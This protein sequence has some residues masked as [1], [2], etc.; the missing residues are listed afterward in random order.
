[1][2]LGRYLAVAASVLAATMPVAAQTVPDAPVAPAPTPAPACSGCVAK[3]TIVEVIIDADLGSKLS[4]TGATFPLHLNKPIVI[5]GRDVV[6]AG[7]AGQGEVVHA[8][9]AG[10]S[11][12]AGEL[13]LAARFLTVGDRQLKLRSMRIALAGRDATGKVDAYNAAAAGAAVLTPLPLGLLGFAITGKNI[14]VPKG[15]LALAKTA[16]DFPVA[17]APA[18]APAPQVQAEK[19]VVAQPPVH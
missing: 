8:K 5:D 15:T 16:E 18:A 14:V 6:P 11:G 3:L 9:K 1:M 2:I 12:A 17:A 10:G 4:T 7:T 13:V 19:A